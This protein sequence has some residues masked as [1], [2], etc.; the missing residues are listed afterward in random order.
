[1]KELVTYIIEGITSST[2]F[3]VEEIVDGRKVELIV[4]ASPD[5]IGLIIGKNGATVKSIRNLLRVKS[6]LSD[7]SVFI[8]VT[9][10]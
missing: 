9:E 3:E 2:D 1:M 7:Q 4:K 8:Q 6:T 10:K 5:I